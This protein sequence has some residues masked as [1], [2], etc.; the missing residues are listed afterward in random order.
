MVA[1]GFTA[2][3]SLL[4]SDH[5]GVTSTKQPPFWEPG[6]HRELF[7]LLGSPLG[8]HRVPFSILGLRTCEKSVQPLYNIHSLYM[9]PTLCTDTP[10]WTSIT[11]YFKEFPRYGQFFKYTLFGSQF[12]SRVPIGSPFHSK[13]GP[14]AIWEKCKSII[15]LEKIWSSH[16]YQSIGRFSILVWA[17]TDRYQHPIATK[18]ITGL[19]WKK[20][21]QCQRRKDEVIWAV[22]WNANPKIIPRSTEITPCLGF[23]D[24]FLGLTHV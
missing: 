12:L 8:P 2:G 1:S 16:T 23:M 5:V 22:I 24:C 15:H 6:P 13:L 17:T 3:G 19:M 18:R 4:V 10:L 21:A 14:H 20:T 9:A 11:S 7:Q